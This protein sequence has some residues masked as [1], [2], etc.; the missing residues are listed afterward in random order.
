[1][2]SAQRARQIADRMHAGGIEVAASLPDSWLSAL[3]DHLTADDRF[4]HVRVT[5]EDDAVAIAGGAAL[6]GSRGVVVCQ[7]AGVLL[8]TN[9]LAAYAHHH[10][11]PVLVVAVERGSARTASTTRRTRA[12]SPPQWPLPPG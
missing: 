2:T 4:T 3:I 7:N 1:M 6:M 5:R 9:V 8:A 12:R 10:Q 11:L